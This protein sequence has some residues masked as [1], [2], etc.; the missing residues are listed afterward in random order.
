M[1]IRPSAAHSY[2]HLILSLRS[3]RDFLIYLFK[4]KN[5]LLIC[6]A[7]FRVYLE[8]GGRKFFGNIRTCTKIHGITSKK[9]VILIFTAIKA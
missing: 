5:I 9:M 2:K 6:A 4:S 1:P 3:P 7:M 8:D